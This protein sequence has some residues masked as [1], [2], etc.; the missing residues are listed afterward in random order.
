MK[1]GSGRPLIDTYTSNQKL[2]LG[3]KEDCN[4]DI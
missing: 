4:D 2:N 3:T 1:D